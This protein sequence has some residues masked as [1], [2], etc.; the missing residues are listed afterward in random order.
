MGNEFHFQG[1]VL[2]N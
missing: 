2:L 1:L